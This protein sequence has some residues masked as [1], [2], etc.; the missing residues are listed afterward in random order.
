M[1][2]FTRTALLLAII[3]Q[4][5]LGAATEARASD[6]KVDQRK[7]T[8]SDD[9]SINFVDDSETEHMKNYRKIS[10]D[11]KVYEDEYSTCI[12]DITDSEY[13]EDK[14]DECVGKNFI[15]VVLDI[16]YETLKIMAKGDTQVRRFFVDYCYVPAGLVEEFSVGCDFMERD[17]LDMLWN[18]LDFVELIEVNKEK[19]LDEYGKV[20]QESFSQVMAQLVAFSKEFFSLIDE[21]DAHKEI[22]ILRLKTL[23]DD[24]TKLII[25]DARNAPSAEIP[26]KV[27]HHIEITQTLSSVREDDADALSA[28]VSVNAIDRRRRRLNRSALGPSHA[29]HVKTERNRRLRGSALSN[30]DAAQQHAPLSLGFNLRSMKSTAVPASSERARLRVFN[31]GQRYAGLHGR[32]NLARFAVPAAFGRRGSAL[33]SS[34]SNLSHFASSFRAQ[35]PLPFK[36]VHSVGMFHKYLL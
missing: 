5:A 28:A 10:N 4:A 21:V 2:P 33:A 1:K 17:T 34:P 13:T 23:I 22:T 16:K 15:K 36:N 18:G 32:T 19:Y 30:Q 24:R 3:L 6:S 26:T 12:K 31:E 8:E 25:E 9:N 14:I 7:L 11:L 29:A 35:S 27:R 20:P